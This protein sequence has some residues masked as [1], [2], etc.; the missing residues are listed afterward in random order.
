MASAGDL[1]GG[2][3]TTSLDLVAGENLT[4]GDAVSLGIDGKA[5]KSIGLSNN[6]TAFANPLPLA[7]TTRYLLDTVASKII[8]LGVDTVDN[9]KLWTSIGTV[10]ASG[11]LTW[12]AVTTHTMADAIG[13]SEA[14][15]A[16]RQS[17]NQLLLAYSRSPS[18]RT[19]II[20]YSG[21]TTTAGTE[22]STTI[23]NTTAGLKMNLAADSTGR[24]LVAWF[25]NTSTFTLWGARATVSGTTITL[26][27]ET[28]ITLPTTPNSATDQRIE[29]LYDSTQD[30][31]L[32]FC[33]YTTPN[34][35]GVLLLIDFSASLSLVTTNN[36]GALTS[37]TGLYLFL[38]KIS[39]TSSYLIRYPQSSSTESRVVT[40][41]TTTITLGTAVTLG[42]NSNTIS[43]ANWVEDTVNNKII[44]GYDSNGCQVYTRSGTTL[45]LQTTDTNIDFTS[46][47]L[48][49]IT[50][51]VVGNFN[52]LQQIYDFSA[53]TP[54]R[55]GT[56]SIH[57]SVISSQS[58]L[59][60]TV[61]GITYSIEREAG[62][63]LGSNIQRHLISRKLTNEDQ[64][65]VST[66]TVSSG[67][68]AK[69]ALRFNK[70]SPAKIVT[71]LSGLVP[72]IDYYVTVA[73][74]RDVA[75]VTYLGFAKSATELVLANPNGA[76]T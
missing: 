3:G 68:T 61:S 52:S 26:G 18:L 37:T 55:V 28:Q 38:G 36:L 30:K 56:L 6:S 31:A 2:S 40:I 24:V 64:I 54:R 57:T 22:V 4:V 47:A 42:Q 58:R 15:D 12:G 60:A 46:T 75:G 35:T 7:T 27:A 74:T 9:D 73:G 13:V 51:Y 71:G 72:G 66:Q 44:F 48:N 33:S 23:T 1:F 10:S 34:F 21:T 11:A 8:A 29:L 16:V 76:E 49:F 45:T 63:K 67:A 50:P 41:S 5:Y 39:G 69:I 19:R 53:A 70:T 43:S 14:W 20:G 32:I 65:G 25:R 59:L 62:A 17:N